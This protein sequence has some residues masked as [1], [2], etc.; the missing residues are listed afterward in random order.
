[1]EHVCSQTSYH[2]C[3]RTI[4][5]QDNNE[6]GDAEGLASLNGIYI[7]KIGASNIQIYF[8]EVTD[9]T[10]V[11]SSTTI[12]TSLVVVLCMLLGLAILELH[13][14][15]VK[16]STVS[17]GGGDSQLFLSSRVSFS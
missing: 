13:R 6:L 16:A 7:T 1:M 8:Q 5:Y 3:A 4:P 15:P 17:A 14:T 11:A 12:R 10:V 2:P 9:V